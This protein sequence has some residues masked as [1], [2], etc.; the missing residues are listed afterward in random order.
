MAGSLPLALL[1]A[2]QDGAMT[3]LLLTPA[4]MR[5]LPGVTV[6]PTPPTAPPSWPHAI[7]VLDGGQL[8]MPQPA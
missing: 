5:L 6:A 7:V 8:L 4:A 3:Q 2:G 1:A